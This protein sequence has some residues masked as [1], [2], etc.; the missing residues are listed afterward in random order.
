MQPSDVMSV[1]MTT[2]PSGKDVLTCST[3]VDGINNIKRS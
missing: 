1:D 3:A 2:R